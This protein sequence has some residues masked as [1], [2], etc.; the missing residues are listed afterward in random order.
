MCVNYILQLINKFSNLWYFFI[1]MDVGVKW[2]MTWQEPRVPW[3][4]PTILS[5]CVNHCTMRTTVY[6]KQSMQFEN[7]FYH[8]ELFS[9]YGWKLKIFEAEERGGGGSLTSVSDIQKHNF[10]FWCSV[11]IRLSGVFCCCCCA[12]L[13][14]CCRANSSLIFLWIFIIV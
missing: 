10:N 7:V 12:E 5:E 14:P 8:L 6:V 2:S 4:N 13:F 11:C 3:E 9:N 1:G